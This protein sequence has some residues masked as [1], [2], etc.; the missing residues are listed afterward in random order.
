MK[1]NRVDIDTSIRMSGRSAIPPFQGGRVFIRLSFGRQL[2]NILQVVER[3]NTPLIPQHM[4]SSAGLAHRSVGRIPRTNAFEVM[5][6]RV[7]MIELSSPSM[8]R[9][10]ETSCNFL[11]HP[12]RGTAL[13]IAS[14]RHF[15]EFSAAPLPWDGSRNASTRNFL[16]F[17]AAPL[18][19]D[20]SRN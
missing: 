11:L 16:E 7:T 17:S 15:L 10:S 18:P 1:W 5:M 4:A 19:W 8:F 6:F 9:I 12:Y 20:G 13:E 3:T 14:T 2:V